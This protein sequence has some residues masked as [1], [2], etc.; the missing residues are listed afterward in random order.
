MIFQGK[1]TPKGPVPAAVTAKK[2]MIQA[3]LAII[4]PDMA[5][6]RL[7]TSPFFS[8]GI[9]TELFFTSITELEPLLL[10]RRTADLTIMKLHTH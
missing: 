2:E 6:V 10:R 9:K 8:C 1:S 5:G 3:T 7:C 4:V